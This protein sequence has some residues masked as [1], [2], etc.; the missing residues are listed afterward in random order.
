MV[1][2]SGTALGQAQAD[3]KALPKCP[4][5]GKPAN[6]AV[7]VATDEGPVFFYC[8]DCV[9]KFKADPGKYAKVVADQRKALADRP[10]VQVTCPVTGKPV[11]KKVFTEHNGEK[12]YFCCENCI[13]KF[14]KEPG[15]YKR[16]LASSYTFQTKCPVM[17]GPINPAA[18]T[19][20]P[21]GEKIYYC[22]PGCDKKLLADPAKYAGKLAEQGIRIDPA[23][24]KKAD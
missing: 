5:T 20:L 14:Q 19:A 4:V 22:C 1:L 23:K 18:F 11:D 7:N 12:V 15:K 13:G 16:A 21:T 3:E 9:E 6:L 17:G 24:I 8:E 10:K 2:T